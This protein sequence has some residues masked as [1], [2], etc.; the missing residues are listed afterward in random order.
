[1]PKKKSN[2]AL[3]KKAQDVFNKWIRARDSEDGYFNCISCGQF[4]PIEKMNAGHYVPVKGG[5]YLR[6]NELNVNGECAY[7]NGFDEFH[8]IGYR[9]NLIEK[10]GG[11]EVEEL[12]KN[13]RVSCKWTRHELEEIIEKYG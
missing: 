9:K 5:S 8:L 2:P 6:F 10:I 3:L 1:M 4:L 11:D 13:R 7:C 12:E